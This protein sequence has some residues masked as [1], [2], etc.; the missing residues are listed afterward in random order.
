MR[1]HDVDTIATVGYMTQNCDESTTRDA[2]HRGFRVEFLSDATG[3]LALANDVGH[4]SARD[5]HEAVLVVLQARFAAVV[6]TDAWGEAVRSGTT[7]TGSD[8][9]TS[10]TRG[11]S[12]ATHAEDHP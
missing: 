6:T 10:A 8:I 7:L 5:L 2:A 1:A 9:V 11:R 12:G 4:V 3:T